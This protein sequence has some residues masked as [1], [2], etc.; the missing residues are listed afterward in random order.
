MLVVTGCLDSPARGPADKDDAGGVDGDGGTVSSPDAAPPCP[1]LVRDTFS[2][3]PIADEIWIE[4]RVGAATASIGAGELKLQAT[5]DDSAEFAV[6]SL[7]S[8][9]SRP[10]ADSHVVASFAAEGDR[11]APSE[12]GVSW[13]RAPFTDYYAV[14]VRGGEVRAAYDLDDSGELPLCDSD[15]VAYTDGQHVTARMAADEDT[16][17]LSVSFDGVTFIDFDP[18]PNSGLGYSV[19]LGVLANPPAEMELKVE[20]VG[21]YDCPPP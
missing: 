10:L 12:A 19:R 6:S 13:M 3:A 4:E 11:L 17:Q 8:H 9:V 5:G 7:A 1:A 15:C 18:A 21:W 2:Q 16:V 14:F 20:N